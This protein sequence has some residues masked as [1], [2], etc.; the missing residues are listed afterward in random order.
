MKKLLLLASFLVVFGSCFADDMPK[1]HEVSEVKISLG[2]KAIVGNVNSF[3]DQL[4]TSKGVT[5]ATIVLSPFIAAFLA[6]YGFEPLKSLLGY[7]AREVAKVK[8][9]YRLHEQAGYADALI[10]FINETPME[11]I[12]VLA[13]NTLGKITKSEI[14]L[15]F[16]FLMSKI[17]HAPKLYKSWLG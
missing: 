13:A 3:L 1:E 7:T 14:A 2:F 5:K 12:K 4:I 6:Y 9:E 16:G 8:A 17:S 11:S 10:N 15:V